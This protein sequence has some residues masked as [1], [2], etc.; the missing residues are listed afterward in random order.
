MKRKENIKLHSVTG[1]S[2][3]GYI[4]SFEDAHREGTNRESKGK[5]R[6]G[7]RNR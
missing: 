5:T 6:D 7:A 4:Y 1:C 2:E 3:V